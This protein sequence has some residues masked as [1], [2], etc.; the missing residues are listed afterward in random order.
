MEKTPII[1]KSMCKE[2]TAHN[3]PLEKT[4]RKTAQEKATTAG[5]A[6]LKAIE[7]AVEVVVDIFD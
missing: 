3:T 6:V 2:N 7:T 1:K 4:D 5:A